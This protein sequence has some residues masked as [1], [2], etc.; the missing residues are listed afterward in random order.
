ML[1]AAHGVRG[2]GAPAPAR[3]HCPQDAGLGLSS[4][5]VGWSR[6]PASAYRGPLPQGVT[7][8]RWVARALGAH[9]TS[10]QLVSKD[11]SPRDNG[12]DS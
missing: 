2:G 3:A 12:G 8:A 7:S 6:G 11:K 4:L 9:L 10:V 5:C 1:G